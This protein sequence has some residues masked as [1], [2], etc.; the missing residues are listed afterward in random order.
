MLEGLTLFW[1]LSEDLLYW[2]LQLLEAACMPWPSS[3]FKV[4]SVMIFFIYFYS[5]WLLL[6]WPYLFLGLWLPQRHLWLH[7]I[8]LGNLCG[9]CWG[10]GHRHLWRGHYLT[11]STYLCL[12]WRY[13]CLPFLLKFDYYPMRELKP[14]FAGIQPGDSTF[15]SHLHSHNIVWLCSDLCGPVH[16]LP[17]V[18]FSP[19]LSQLPSLVVVSPARL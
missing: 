19:V 1:R 14:Q 13:H 12:L 11:C 5:L 3:I 17:A 10:L 18:T 9:R 2:F 6:P 16:I 8:H 15:S 7:W 4:S